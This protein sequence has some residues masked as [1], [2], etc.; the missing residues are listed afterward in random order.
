M[1]KLREFYES[2]TG[3]KVPDD[4]E[5]HHLNQNRKD[6]AIENLVAIPKKLHTEYHK[7]FPHWITQ[8]P[9]SLDTFTPAGGVAG[10]NN[11]FGFVLDSLQNHYEY[12]SQI[13]TWVLY[14]DSLIGLIFNYA[15]L[16]YNEK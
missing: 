7:T 10:T 9:I 13:Q 6:D 12:F 8:Q 14:R 15:K 11:E 2:E 1:S 5:I 3:L 4:F 16:S